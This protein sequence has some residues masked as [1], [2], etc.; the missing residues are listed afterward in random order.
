MEAQDLPYLGILRYLRLCTL[1]LLAILQVNPLRLVIRGF[2]MDNFKE[3][4]LRLLFE[5]TFELVKIQQ[6]EVVK[7]LKE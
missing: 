1:K 5:L 4:E 2:N 3:Y 6:K 7:I